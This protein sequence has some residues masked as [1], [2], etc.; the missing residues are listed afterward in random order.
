MTIS[1]KISDKDK[2]D[3]DEIISEFIQYINQDSQDLSTDRNVVKVKVIKPDP[4]DC[5]SCARTPVIKSGG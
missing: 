1:N 3:L 2:I 4:I 5:S